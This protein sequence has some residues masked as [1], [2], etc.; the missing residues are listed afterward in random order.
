MPLTTAVILAAGMGVRLGALGRTIPKGFLQLGDQPIV[1]ESIAQLHACGI[2]RI[3][4]VTGHLHQWYERLQ[5]QSGGKI[6]TVHNPRY[7]DSGSMYSLYCARTL[8]D[9][10]VL[11]LESDLIYEPRA[12]N[13]LLAVPD[14]D[15][16][17]LSGPTAAGDEVYAEVDGARLVGLSKDRA[18]L[19]NVAGEF[20]GISKMSYSMFGDMLDEATRSFRHSLQIAYETDTLV[21]V[22][23]RRPVH[24]TLLSDLVWAEID[25]T[26][27]LARAR[28]PIYPAIVRSRAERQLQIRVEQPACH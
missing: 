28:D 19:R 10:A 5:A 26:R 27:H 20:V 4:I 8:I 14:E 3:I 7:A 12:L 21:A 16:V 24:Y 23:Q 25:D 18:S 2:D 9:G 17:L 15:A 22:A 6:I 13:T 11:V 1:A